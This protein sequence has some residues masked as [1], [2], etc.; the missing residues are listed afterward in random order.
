MGDAIPA[1]DRDKSPED[2]Q[3][4]AAGYAH[5]PVALETLGRLLPPRHPS[6]IYEALMEGVVLFTVLWLVRTR[7]K[8]PVG[9]L[10][11]LF[12]LLYAGL[13]IIGEEFR[14]PDVGIPFTLGFTRGQFLSLFMI[15]IGAAFVIYSLRT[16]QPTPAP[17]PDAA[18]LRP[19]SAVLLAGGRSTRMGRDKALLPL[20]DGRLLW[21]RQL[22]VLEQLAPAELFFSGPPREGLPSQSSCWKTP[23]P[24]PGR[25]RVWCGPWRSMR[26]P[27][28]AGAGGRPARDDAGVPGAAVGERRQEESF[29]GSR[30]LRA[31]GGGLSGGGPAACARRGLRSPDHSLQGLVRAA[32]EA[33]VVKILDVTPADAP[34]FV[35]WN[36]PGDY[37]LT[38][39]AA[40]PPNI[41]GS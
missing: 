12:F 39:I 35:N 5:D 21:Q 33:K 29:R 41:G 11:G 23:T 27:A 28:A 4:A 36:H 31:D 1:G 24:M 40:Q 10:T 8:A 14:Q 13:R 20:A 18:A 32:A 25:W 30:A 15:L 19:F 6:Q 9:M 16:R 2:A 7:T 38:N 3:L 34:L 22:A 17:A 37:P 26:T